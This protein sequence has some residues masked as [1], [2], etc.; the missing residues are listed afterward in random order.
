[1]TSEPPKRCGFSSAATAR[2]APVSRSTSSRTTVVVPTSM[3]TPTGLPAAAPRSEPSSPRNRPSTTVTAGSSSG[4][5]PGASGASRIRSRRRRTA[6]STS[7]S[8]RS[9]V[10]W[11]AS[12][13]VGPRKPSW[14][15]RGESWSPPARISTTHSWQR[16]VRLHEA[17]T[18]T[19][20]WSASS[21]RRR[22]ETSGRRSDPWITW[23][24]RA[25]SRGRARRAGRSLGPFPRDLPPC[26]PRSS[27]AD[28]SA[29]DSILGGVLGF[30]RPARRRWAHAAL[31]ALRPAD[32]RRLP[33]A[34]RGQPDD[35]GA[36]G[37]RA[38]RRR[39]RRAPARRGRP[40]ERR[41]AGPRAGSPSWTGR[42]RSRHAP[43]PS[44]TGPA[45]RVSRWRATT[46]SSGPGRTAS[47]SSTTAR[48]SGAPRSCRTP[49]T[50]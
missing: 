41:R 13:N 33:V 11:Q 46:S 42:C 20:S 7:R 8:V 30:V 29:A 37:G 45:H 23:G 28:A 22:P 19:E 2:I 4:A 17:G 27:G 32:A 16:P 43:S 10:A 24:I 44:T 50:A 14:S 34:A 48:A 1:M 18:M 38:P 40:R 9:T 25:K 31:A 15:V 5:S 12:R 49:A 6:N 3:A 21:Y 35:P 26:R 47:T 36:H 39:G